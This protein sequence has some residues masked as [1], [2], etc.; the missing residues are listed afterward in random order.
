MS[1]ETP[2]QQFMRGLRADMRIRPLIPETLA[3]QTPETVVLSLALAL[4][5]ALESKR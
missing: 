3:D 1:E 2:F 5:A 4:A